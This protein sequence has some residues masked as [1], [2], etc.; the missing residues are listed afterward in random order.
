MFDLRLSDEQLATRETVRNFVNREIKPIANR[1]DLVADFSERF[2]WDIVTKGSQM[3][4]RTT[5]LSVENGGSYVDVLTESIIGEELG[6]G[7][8]GVA[9]TLGQTA[10]LAHNYYD[11]LMNDEQRKR[12]LPAFLAD[13]T[14]HLAI[15]LH[16][17]DTDVGYDYF[18]NDIP[19]SGDKTRAVQRKDGSWVIEG[20]KSFQTNGTI[21]KLLA[22]RARTEWG[23]AAFLVPAETPGLTRIQID[24]AGRRLAG[25]GELYFDDCVVPDENRLGKIGE[26]SRVG[27]GL[28]G[29]VRIASQVLGVG[30]AAYEAALDYAQVRVQGGKPI[31]QHQAVGIALA[32]M[33]TKIDAA[34]IMIWQVAWVID[35]FRATGSLNAMA[36]AGLAGKNPIVMTR[37]AAMNAF[38]VAFDV[39]CRASTIFGGAGIAREYPMQKYIRDASVYLHAAPRDVGLLRI[40]EG[41][42]GFHRPPNAFMG[43]G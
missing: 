37:M 35:Q 11:M 39:A 38:Q 28:I 21:A 26:N 23:S 2:P 30:R 7:D 20:A 15:A 32:E 4:L 12:F 17:P 22:V 14:Y 9:V 8:L 41:L 13:D 29:G 34:R 33:A 3:G 36:E 31:I 27:L 19:G 5:S 42:A 25:W 1:L 40:A 18:V 43:E 24:G 10:G 16:E 6:A